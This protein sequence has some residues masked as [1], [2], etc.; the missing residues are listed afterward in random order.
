M[1][2]LAHKAFKAM[3]ITVAAFIITPIVCT[4]LSAVLLEYWFKYFFNVS[5]FD[6][7]NHNFF[8][9]VWWVL[10][11]LFHTKAAVQWWMFNDFKL[12]TKR[13]RR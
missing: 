10:F 9:Q 7:F 12:A 2:T 3:A 5:L 4:I 8:A 1:T 11:I 13:K 6:S